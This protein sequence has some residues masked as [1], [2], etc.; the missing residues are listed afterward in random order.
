MTD[1]WT[2]S[3]PSAIYDALWT[4]LETASKKAG[5]PF[6]TPTIGTVGGMGCRVRT[7][8]L[9]GAD[10]AVPVLW[11]H[12]DVRSA[13]VADLR[14]N[15]F[16]A[17]HFYDHDKK[18][19]IRCEGTASV[20]WN[21]EM[22]RAGWERSALSSRRCYTCLHPPGTPVEYPDSGLPPE[23]IERVP[24]QEESELGW[25][26]FSLVRSTIESIDW[27]YLAAKGHR[28]ATFRFSN[29]TLSSKWLI[30]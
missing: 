15:P 10:R 18:I 25:P 28:R 17:W 20:H 21:D 29:G 27:L 5:L 1:V 16:I 12:T 9:R 24:T 6:H 8:V 19:Q 26:N 23:F 22:A 2:G 11:F 4:E 14:A 13:K 7:V 30:P 3:D